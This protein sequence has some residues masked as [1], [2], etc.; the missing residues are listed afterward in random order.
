MNYFM[1]MIIGIDLQIVFIKPFQN[2]IQFSQNFK[3]QN[4]LLF[5]IIQNNNPFPGGALGFNLAEIKKL[6]F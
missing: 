5:N 3:S 2:L 4:N 1:D 6:G